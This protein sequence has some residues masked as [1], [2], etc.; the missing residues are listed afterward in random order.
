MKSKRLW[1]VAENEKHIMEVSYSWREED[2]FLT[3][4]DVTKYHFMGLH[5]EHIAPVIWYSSSNRVAQKLFYKVVGWLDSDYGVQ[6]QHSHQQLE[7]NYEPKYSKHSFRKNLVPLKYFMLVSDV[8]QD[9]IEFFRKLN[10][11]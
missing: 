3:A 4:L 6:V 11:T 5:T 10:I 1:V 7:R 9:K 2:N 8:A